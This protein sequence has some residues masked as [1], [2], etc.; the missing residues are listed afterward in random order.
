MPTEL[1]S[2]SPGGRYQVR[3]NAWEARNSL[4][5]E[6]PE[7]Y[8][9]QANVSP[10]TFDSEL[11]SLDQSEWLSE[12]IVTLRLRKFPGN[13]LPA[14]VGVSVDCQHRTA[15]LEAGPRVKLE[16]LEP[17]LECHLVWSSP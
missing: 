14:Q 8:D 4:W 12:S 10:L 7:I 2:S 15:Q 16:E 6:S 17:L 9:S 3:V 11:W 13:H 1:R 5:V